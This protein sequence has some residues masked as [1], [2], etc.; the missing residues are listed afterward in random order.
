VLFR[1]DKY[2]PEGTNKLEVLMTKLAG[3]IIVICI[4]L[5]M[6]L[7]IFKPKKGNQYIDETKYPVA[8]A[9]YILE[10][11]DVKNIKLYNEYNYGSYLLYRDIPV[12]IDSRVDLYLPEFN[13]DI[14]VFTD[15]LA[16]S[17]LNI[18]NVDETLEKYGITHL[19]M[20]SKA[21]LRVFLDENPEDYREIYDDNNF[22]IYEEIKGN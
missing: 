13:K 3:Q 16:V 17:N 15:F 12:F 14:E 1:S 22:C 21:K 9:N 8:A 11:L 6:S 20:Y 5:I 4:V 18:S 10:N 7:Q 2:D 19:I